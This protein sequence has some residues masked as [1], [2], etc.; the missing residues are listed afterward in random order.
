MDAAV[1]NHHRTVCF[2]RT[3]KRR[4]RVVRRLVIADGTDNVRR[5]IHD[6]GD[7]W[8][9]WCHGVDGQREALGGIADVP[10]GIDGFHR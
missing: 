7:H 5:I 4:R 8:L 6:V 9:N 10:C 3:V 1:I 2:C